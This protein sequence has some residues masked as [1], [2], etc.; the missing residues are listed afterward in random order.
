MWYWDILNLQH[1]S[2]CF[3]SWTNCC[4][5]N[6][7]STACIY[8]F[9]CLSVFLYLSTWLPVE[10]GFVPLWTGEEIWS[11]WLLWFLNN[12]LV[13]KSQSCISSSHIP[14]SAL[15]SLLLLTPLMELA[16]SPLPWGWDCR[17]RCDWQPQEG[18]QVRTQNSSPNYSALKTSFWCKFKYHNSCN[19]YSI[20]FSFIPFWSGTVFDYSWCSRR[21]LQHNPSTMNCS[22]VRVASFKPCLSGK[23]GAFTGT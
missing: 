5:E 4:W 16:P 23:L 21:K 9:M 20:P 19:F 1:L 3:C 17:S 11:L 10:P 14:S 2:P 15:Q 18:Q 8:V 13:T 6:T 12:K 22:K 7:G